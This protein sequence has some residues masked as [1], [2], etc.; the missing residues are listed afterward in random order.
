L[1]INFAEYKWQVSLIVNDFLFL[2]EQLPNGT[3]DFLLVKEIGEG[4]YEVKYHNVITKDQ[5]NTI[6]M[7]FNDTRI[8]WDY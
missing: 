7:E 6:L 8:K 3:F 1:T 4:K 5:L 2:F